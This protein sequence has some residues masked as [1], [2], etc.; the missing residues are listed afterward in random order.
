M[1]TDDLFKRFL[2]ILDALEK[3]KVDYVLIGGFAMVLYGM[4]RATQDIDIFIKYQQENIERLQKALYTIFNN[5][6]VFEIT[7]SEFQDFPVIRYGAEEGYYIDILA[8]I[9]TT[10]SFDDLIFQ[11][12]SVEDHK[13]KI[14]SVETLYKLKEKTFRAIDKS[15]LLFLQQIMKN[16]K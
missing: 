8:N 4:P 9:G 2:E 5:K 3:E 16:K 12:I 13:I 7:F 15:D 6:N 10:F 11:E 1:Q 14:A